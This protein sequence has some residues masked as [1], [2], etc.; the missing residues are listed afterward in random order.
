MVLAQ[1]EKQL[2]VFNIKTGKLVF[3]ANIRNGASIT[4]LY[5]ADYAKLIAI[6]RADSTIDLFDL[7][8]FNFSGEPI[9]LSILTLETLYRT[10]TQSLL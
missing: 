8:S 9:V 5:S 4:G 1:E 3:H 10:Q 7:E 6:S 2:R